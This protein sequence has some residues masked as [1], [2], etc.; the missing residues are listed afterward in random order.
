MANLE[1]APLGQEDKV[2]AGQETVTEQIMG[3]GT[4]DIIDVAGKKVRIRGFTAPEGDPGRALMID[5]ISPEEI[6][7][8]E[9]KEQTILGKIKDMIKANPNATIDAEQARKYWEGLY[10]KAGNGEKMEMQINE[11]YA[12]KYEERAPTQFSL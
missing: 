11:M 1:G 5:E 8:Y 3:I 7:A 2:E 9:L 10:D 4:G 12:Q 6:R